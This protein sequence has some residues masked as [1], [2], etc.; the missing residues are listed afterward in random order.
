MQA[1][2][3]HV[4]GVMNFPMQGWNRSREVGL[5]GQPRLVDRQPIRLTES[6]QFLWDMAD[7][8]A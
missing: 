4:L 7:M 5:D 1:I 3:R 2:V 6:A 8:H